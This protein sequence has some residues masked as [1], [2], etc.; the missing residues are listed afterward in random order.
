MKTTYFYTVLYVTLAAAAAIS[1]DGRKREIIARGGDV[2]EEDE[3]EKRTLVIPR[4]GD[5]EEEDEYEKRAL[6]ARGGDVEE[7]DEYEK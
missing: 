7:E 5:V 2:E 6:T 1:R 3:Y 4:G